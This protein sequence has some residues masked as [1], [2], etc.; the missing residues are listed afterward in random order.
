MIV[1]D[2]QLESYAMFL[3]ENNGLNWLQSQTKLGIAPRY[4]LVGFA[5]GKYLMSTNI[6]VLI[7]D[8]AILLNTNR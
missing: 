8:D 3:Y 6:Y 4:P 1:T 2:G 5:A 7:T